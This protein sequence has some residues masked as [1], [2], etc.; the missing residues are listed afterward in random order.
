MYG[1]TTF[2][3]LGFDDVMCVVVILYFPQSI[4]LLF[5]QYREEHHDSSIN[6]MV[7]RKHGSGYVHVHTYNV[8]KHESNERKERLKEKVELKRLNVQVE[9]LTKS[10]RQYV[11]IKPAKKLVKGTQYGRTTVYFC[12]SKSMTSYYK[13]TI[14]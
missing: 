1:G 7:K 11:E 5:L 2:V 3:V 13:E 9:T 14:V 8:N 4:V 6:T 10:L 12:F